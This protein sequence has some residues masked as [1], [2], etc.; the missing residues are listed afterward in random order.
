MKKQIPRLVGVVVLV[1]AFGLIRSSHARPAAAGQND[2]THK[3]QVKIDNFSFSPSPLTV[4]VGSTITWTNQ[5]DVPHN[6]IST[7]G[8]ALKSPVLD[9]NEKFSYTFTKAGVYTYYCAIHPKMT[10]KVVVQ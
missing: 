1:L 3:L 4:P 10:G 8:K 5:D 6:V 9:T 7:E 2:S